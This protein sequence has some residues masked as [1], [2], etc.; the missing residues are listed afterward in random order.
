MRAGSPGGRPVPAMPGGPSPRS[1]APLLRPLLLLLCALAPGAPGP[2]PGGCPPLPGQPA[3]LPLPAPPVSVLSLFTFVDPAPAPLC[4][5]LVASSA[6]RV[7]GD[8]SR[9]RAGPGAKPRFWG[10]FLGP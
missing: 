9:G 2:A 5:E 1:P 4:L 7:L 3:L 10:N 6:P 8:S